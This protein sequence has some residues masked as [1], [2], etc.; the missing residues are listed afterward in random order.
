VQIDCIDEETPFQIV[1]GGLTNQVVY[2]GFEG[3]AAVKCRG[4][5]TAEGYVSPGDLEDVLATYEAGPSFHVSDWY[6]GCPCRADQ[7]ADTR[8]YN[9]ARHQLALFE[10]PKHTDVGQAFKAAAAENEGKWAF[11]NHEAP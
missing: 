2:Q 1:E 4:K 7:G 11:W 5:E 10:G 9:E 6:T 3:L 8:P